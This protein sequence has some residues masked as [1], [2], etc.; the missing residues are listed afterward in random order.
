[1]IKHALAA[2]GCLVT[3]SGAGIATAADSATTATYLFSWAGM[4][5][6]ELR[7][8]IVET[9]GA[10]RATWSGRTIGL[11]GALFPFTSAGTADGHRVD[12]RYQAGT[13]DA[14]SAWRDGGTASRVMFGPDGRAIEIEVPPADLTDREP[15]PE[16]LRRGP[17]PA[18]LALLAI[19]S[20]R[21]GA[22][23]TA[24]SFD[25]K[26]AVAFVL[27]CQSGAE[28]TEAGLT[29]TIRSRLLAGAARRWGDQ[30]RQAAEPRPVQVWLQRSGPVHVFWPARVEAPSRFG[31]IEVR[32]SCL[33]QHEPDAG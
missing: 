16:A 6:G 10:Y 22:G 8:E 23:L 1:V 4:D 15:V 21:P 26:R 5:V 20:A 31:T 32:L 17:D 11:V 3:L 30:Q 13:Y 33:T 25:G 29:C 7:V 14:H 2:L 18:S 27:A 24:T 12:G 19:T 9:G 28:V